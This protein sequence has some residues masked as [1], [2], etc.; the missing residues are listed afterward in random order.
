MFPPVDEYVNALRLVAAGNEASARAALEAISLQAPTWVPVHRALAL[1]AIRA[2]MTAEYDSRFALRLEQ[3][4]RDPGAAIGHALLLA[5]AGQRV[6][7]HRWLQTAIIAGSRDPLLVEPLLET[8]ASRDR[9]VVWLVSEA[10][11]ASQD[12]PLAALAVR[13][14]LAAGDRNRAQIVLDDALRRHPGYGDLHSLAARL[15]LLEGDERAACDSAALATS[16]LSEEQTVPE[17]RIP[18]RVALARIFTACG[19]LNAARQVLSAVGPVLRVPGEP[20]WPSLVRMANAEVSIA[21]G[22]PLAALA[23]INDEAPLVADSVDAREWLGA[24]RAGAFARLDRPVPNAETLL[25]EPP[26]SPAALLDR[27]TALSALWLAPADVRP[28]RASEAVGQI[29]FAIESAG[30]FRRAARAWVLAAFVAEDR[31][32]GR[33][34][35]GNALVLVPEE[36]APA[37]LRAAVAVVRTQLALREQR[38]DDAVAASNV[39]LS[40]LAGAPG[41]LLARLESLAAEAALTTGDADS[42]MRHARDGT[43][44]LQEAERSTGA[45]P[46][47]LAPLVED[48]SDTALTLASLS[49]RATRAAGASFGEAGATLLRQLRRGVRRWSLFEAQW[50]ETLDD[51]AR[52]APKNSCLVVAA[53]GH[54]AP[55]L[56]AANGRV[57]ESTSEAVLKSA[58]CRDVR[59][60]LWAGPAPAPIGLTAALSDSR[61][62]VRLTGPAP[63]P[64]GPL[65]ETSSL[66]P[67]WTYPA[68]SGPD[69]SFARLIESLAQ[70]SP[71]A[72]SSRSRA[73]AVQDASNA[74]FIGAGLAPPRSPLSSGWLVPPAASL[75]TGWLGPDSLTGLAGDPASGLIAVG[76]RA[77]TPNGADRGLWLL[78]EGSL[79]AGW[80]WV[81]LSRIPLTD[82]HRLELAARSSEWA[83]DPVREARRLARLDPETASALQ[84]WS[85]SGRLLRV[86]TGNPIDTLFYVPMVA[87]FVLA[88]LTLVRLFRRSRQARRLSAPRDPR[89]HPNSQDD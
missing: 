82:K 41:A 57:E 49:F 53:P 73:G 66:Q 77:E 18:R 72:S 79:A 46:V 74:F 89:D 39:D 59:I 27:L 58:A 43:L 67:A 62:L 65:G 69:R 52:L 70:V 86:K 10:T 24:L 12:A 17:F 28:A 48:P 42:A 29:A 76:I 31:D 80:R 11:R 56:A 84:L 51:L 25:S 32:A 78:A 61:V 83:E 44:D 33:R 23:S 75:R 68:G 37:E 9:L 71:R 81:L 4:P 34:A 5:A 20:P 22:D 16:Y 45:V 19:R 85:A 63:I 30:L 8:A 38:L 60:V 15:D 26:S 35:L 47:E 13:V 55:A 14:S 40:R 87:G 1:A 88:A 36:S 2:G 54:S 7:A 3:N 21:A 6:E 64:D 50:P